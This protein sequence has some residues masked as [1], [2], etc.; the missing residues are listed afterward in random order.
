MFG[1]KF[2]F[3]FA[4]EMRVSGKYN[5]YTNTYTEV[6]NI[7]WPNGFPPPDVPLCGF[8]GEKCAKSKLTVT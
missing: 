2:H 5:A 6:E 7:S 3:C 8:N 1:S 4:G